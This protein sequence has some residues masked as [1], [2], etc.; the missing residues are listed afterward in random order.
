VGKKFFGITSDARFI[1]GGRM[2]IKIFIVIFLSFIL[3]SCQVSRHNAIR[4]NEVKIHVYFNQ[5]LLNDCIAFLQKY[6]ARRIIVSKSLKKHNDLY[7]D[8]DKTK[9][10]T[11]VDILKECVSFINKQ[12]NLNIKIDISN[13][14]IIIHE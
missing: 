3:I 11:V 14:K 13:D 8:F 6:T 2:R 1:E 7:V 4:H 9:K 5:S 12:H 10:M